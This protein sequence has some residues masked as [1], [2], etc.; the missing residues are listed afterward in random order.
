MADYKKGGG[1]GSKGGY[2]KK[3]WS[4]DRGEV[5]MHRATCAE[6]KKSCSVPFR[7][8]GD[9]PVYCKD[10]FVVKGGRDTRIDTRFPRKDFATRN[11]ERPSSGDYKTPVHGSNDDIRRSI[12][13]LNAKV[14]RLLQAVEKLSR[15]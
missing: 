4:P 8:S 9:K 3:E 6:C 14:D 2:K 13:D 1:Y 5:E 11:A 10:C 7:P 15:D 12:Q